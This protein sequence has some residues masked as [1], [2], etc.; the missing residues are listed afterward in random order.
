MEAEGR[1]G[2]AYDHKLVKAGASPCLCHSPTERYM[3][4]M[5]GFVLCADDF[6]MTPGISRGIL[7][8]LA[9]GRLSAT[10]AMTNR[11]H[12]PDFAGALADFDGYADLGVHLNLTCGRPL[13]AMPTL[14]PG[15]ELPK[16]PALLKLAMLGKLPSAEI[17]AEINTQLDS[18]ELLMGRAPDFIDGHQHVHGLKGVQKIFLDVIRRRY[19]AN[20]RR[21]YIRVSG[22]SI[23]RILRRGRFIAKAMQVRQL[24]INFGTLL[25]SA[26][27][28]TNEGFAG[29]STFD[30]KADYAAQ[31]ASYLKAPGKRHL[32]MCHPGFVDDELPT[33]DPVLYSRERELEFFRGDGLLAA[34]ERA[35]AQMQSMW[36]FGEKPQESSKIAAGGSRRMTP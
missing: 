4:G 19:P 23:P 35:G 15:G 24:S 5:F 7:E 21:P 33:I 30:D 17:A 10:G 11:P 18:F 31:F 25:R 26:G 32:I 22:D 13:R 28:P 29:F 3:S 36:Q 27:F 9:G 6:A 34:C 2:Q 20:L 8:L 16:L 1:R 12:W 14:A